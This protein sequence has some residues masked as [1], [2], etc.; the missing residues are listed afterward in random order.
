MMEIVVSVFVMVIPP[1]RY[2]GFRA[3]A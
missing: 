3:W 1:Y 2:N